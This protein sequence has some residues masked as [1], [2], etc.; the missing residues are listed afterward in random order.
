M[1]LRLRTAKHLGVNGASAY[2]AI[3][4]MEPGRIEQYRRA[5]MRL[6]FII[7]VIAMCLGMAIAFLDGGGP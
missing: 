5:Q 1:A 6:Y 4:K 7:A 2:R 3:R